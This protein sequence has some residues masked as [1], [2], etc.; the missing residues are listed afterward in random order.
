MQLVTV[1][2]QHVHVTGIFVLLAMHLKWLWLILPLVSYGL[3][4]GSADPS[5]PPP[6]PPTGSTAVIR[7][8]VVI[9]LRFRNVDELD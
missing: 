1:I 6:L 9:R 4:C 3:Y 7:E 2:S 5:D 8:A